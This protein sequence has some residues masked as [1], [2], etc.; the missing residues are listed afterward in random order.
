MVQLERFWATCL[1]CPEFEGRTMTSTRASLSM[2]TSCSATTCRPQPH[3]EDIRLL[4]RSSSWPLDWT[5]CSQLVHQHVQQYKKCCALNPFFFFYSPL[6]LSTVWILTLLCP[7]PMW[8][9]PVLAGLSLVSPLEH[10]SSPWQ[11]TISCLMASKLCQSQWK[12]NLVSMHQNKVVF[13]SSYCC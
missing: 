2:K 8:T 1:R 7:T 13:F 4:Q 5:R 11:P 9:S 10:P 3:P 6:S 12:H